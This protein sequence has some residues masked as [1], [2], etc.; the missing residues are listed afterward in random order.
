MTT[1]PAGSGTRPTAAV[2]GSGVAGLTSAYL[3]QRRYDVTLFE[4][5]DRI[6]G[7]AH[8]HDI[9]TSDGRVIPV[10]TGFIVHNE[11]TYP[12]LLRLFGELG[13]ATQGTEMSMSIKCEGCGLEYAGARGLNG[14]FAQRPRLADPRFVRML[15]E[16]KRFHRHAHRLLAAD[17]ATTDSITLGAF[18]AIGGYS[19]YFVRHFMIPVVS[20]VWSSGT[21]LSMQYPARY[22]FT[23]LDNHGMLT[24]KNSPTWRTVVGGSRAYVDKAAKGLTAVQTSSPVRTLRRTVDGVEI[25]DQDGQH[26]RRDVVVVATHPDQALRLL[27]EPTDE[28]RSVL[29]AFEYSTNETLLHTD[30]AVLPRA[31]NA[32]ASWNYL[33]SCGAARRSPHPGGWGNGCGQDVD[34]VQVTYWMN[35]LQQLD[36]P[37]NYLVTLNSN[38][39]IAQDTVL[40][41]MVYDHPLYTPTSV[42]AQ[43]LLPALNTGRTAFAGA[44]H[45]W[46]FHE[47]GC[48]AGVRAAQSFGVGW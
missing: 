27:G 18:L 3:L 19:D 47:D 10:D 48:A 9:P 32:R 17:P 4:A 13:V 12:H 37:V 31:E 23:F 45:G 15:L 22:L 29:G 14:V 6:G 21:E 8:T 25:F 39:R 36:E 34:R 44:Y 1:T 11:R 43:R 20:C 7:H 30:T 5:D 41:R 28:E 35:K 42:A 38:S 16:V 24:V 46:G 2:I 33:M 26:H 40:A